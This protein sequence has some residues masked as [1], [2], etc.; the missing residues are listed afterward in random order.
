MSTTHPLDPVAAKISA[1]N[2]SIYYGEKR[3][4][5]DV[6]IDIPTEYVTAFIGPSGCGK[7][8]FLRAL[9]RMNDTIVGARVEGEITLDGEDIYKSGMDVVQLRARVGMVF[10]KP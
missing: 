2:V 3:A 10:Q 5:D 8:T 7:S 6:S 4:I 9:N 1:R